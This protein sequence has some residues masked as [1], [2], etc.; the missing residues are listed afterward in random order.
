MARGRR[1]TAAREL[2]GT[3]T[4]ARVAAWLAAAFCVTLLAA[5][6]VEHAAHLRAR[7]D[8]TSA[9]WPQPYT[10]FRL[11][12]SWSQM[13]RVRSPR[14]AW[15]LVPTLRQI[16]G[17]EDALEDTSVLTAAV[18][19]RAQT[20]LT[21]LLGAGNEQVYVGRDGELFYRQD[22]DYVTGRGF[23]EP[24]RLA[25]RASSGPAWEDAPSPDP[26]PAI[27]ALHA[28]LAE[29]DIPLVV[30]PIPVKPVV[31]NAALARLPSADSVMNNP[32]Y[33]SFVESVRADGID[34]YDPTEDIPVTKGRYL[35]TDS[36]WTPD[37][38]EAV[39]AGIARRVPATG[40]DGASTSAP[41]MRRPARVANTGDVAAMLSLSPGSPLLAPEAT[42]VEEV[43]RSD[44]GPWKADRAARVLLLGDSFTNIYS[45]GAMGWGSSAGLAAQLSYALQEPVD[46]IALNAGGARAAREALAQELARGE[47]RLAGKDVVVYTFAAR[48][49]YSGDWRVFNMPYAPES[50][51]QDTR[52][53]SVVQATVAAKSSPPTPGSVPYPDC[54]IAYHATD[55][56]P[57][58]AAT[59]PGEAVVFLWGMRDNEWTP[60]AA[61]AVG[62]PVRLR[63]TPWADVEHIY[64]GH[65]RRELDDDATWLL[66]VYWG[67]I[68]P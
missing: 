41:Y 67:E 56:R 6:A 61:T 20:A 51:A 22:V 58:G 4:T 64:G 28:A 10:V 35:R 1:D 44:G 7:A 23:L 68:V 39:A 57:A 2:S 18:R 16:T 14:N 3:Q 30:A 66:D 53:A 50:A 34:V 24:D 45:L 47:D 13:A 55:I 60:A 62:S 8:G 52:V 19:P 29:R 43:L 65:S 25:A 49:L 33:A 48:E 26:R 38:M 63:L 17:Y 31:Q 15:A 11:L 46:T 32:S 9:G 27:R 54:V 59:V 5:A 37:T 36:H 21:A 40:T 12:P 42:E